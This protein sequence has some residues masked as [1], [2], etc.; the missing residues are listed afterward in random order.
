MSRYWKDYDQHQIFLYDVYFSVFLFFNELNP[1]IYKYIV[2]RVIRCD[3]KL[4]MRFIYRKR[5]YDG[6]Y[7]KVY[8]KLKFKYKHTYSINITKFV[9]CINYRLCDKYEVDRTLVLSRFCYQFFIF[10]K[11]KRFEDRLSPPCLHVNNNR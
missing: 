11:N 4:A 1:S 7:V 9:I 6:K 3:W 5:C 10:P 8:I 2:S